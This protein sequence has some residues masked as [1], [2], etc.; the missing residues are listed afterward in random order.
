VRKSWPPPGRYLSTSTSTSPKLA[1][2]QREAGGGEGETDSLC[3][4]QAWEKGEEV[5]IVVERLRLSQKMVRELEESNVELDK[6]LHVS[7][8]VVQ[9]AKDAEGKLQEVQ[10]QLQLLQ[11]QRLNEQAERQQERGGERESIARLETALARERESRCAAEKRVG[12]LEALLEQE[13]ARFRDDG[14]AA[15]EETASLQTALLHAQ[16]SAGRN[17]EQKSAC[18]KTFDINWR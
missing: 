13:R 9:S 17:Y 4:E 6:A 8:A 1:L 2:R 16:R 7:L 18:Y 10:Q 11:Q 12:E 15:V 3:D 5:E 14:E